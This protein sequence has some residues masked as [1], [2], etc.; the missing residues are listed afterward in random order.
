MRAN[1]RFSRRAGFALAELIATIAVLAI[2]SGISISSYSG[3]SISAR[4]GVARD[5]VALL[6]RALLHFNQVN[7]DIVLSPQANSASDELAVL[8]SLQWRDPDPDPR[9]VSPGSPYISASFDATVSSSE[10]DFRII[11]NGRAFELLAPGTPG[12]GLRTGTRQPEGNSSYTF[13]SGYQPI[14]PA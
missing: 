8:R 6:N 5:N 11:W 7:W 12:T 13:P 10:D 1:R 4:E 14:G 9:K 2:L 3:L